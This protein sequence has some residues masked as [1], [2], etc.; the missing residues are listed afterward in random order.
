MN[1]KKSSGKRLGIIVNPI[2]GR[3]RAVRGEERIVRYL[4]SKRHAFCIEHTNGPGHA[5]ALARRMCREFDILL[6]AG[7]DGTVNEVACG[8]IRGTAALSVLPIGSGNDFGRLLGIPN[9]VEH[10]IDRILSGTIRHF[11]MGVIA[12]R[13]IHGDIRRRFFVNTVGMG[14]DAEIANETKQIRILRGLPLYLFA[15]IRAL[16]RHVPNEYAIVQKGKRRKQ[17]AFFVCAGNGPYEGGGF[18]MIPDARPD[19]QMLHWCM[20]QAV[21]LYRALHLIPRMLRG[22]HTEYPI[23]STWKSNKATIIGTQPFIVH[24][25]GEIVDDRARQV[26]IALAAEQLKV[27]GLEG[28]E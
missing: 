5:T 10:A 19:D 12:V 24:V 18:R 27:I 3:G 26:D 15:A 17:N 4:R 25:D 21:P 14:L 13:N 8:M 20:V 1:N 11:D 23:V 22:S 7:G 16:R 2:A 9:N 6:A 28:Q